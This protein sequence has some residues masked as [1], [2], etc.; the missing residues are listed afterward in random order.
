VS[1]MLA[2]AQMA[3]WYLVERA[4]S[5]SSPREREQALRAIYARHSADVLGVCGWWLG[6][7]DAAMDAAQSTFEVAIE[8]LAGVGPAGAPTLRDPDKLGAWLRGIAKNQCRAAWRRRDREGEFPEEDLEDAEH[9]VRASRR[10]Q[11]QVDRMLDSVAASFTQRQQAIFRLVLRQGIRGQALAAELGVSEKDANDA[12]YENQALVLDGFGAYVLARDGRAYCGGLARILDQAA[13]NGETFTRVL[14]L[15]ILRHLDDC[16]ICDNCRTCNVQ[17]RRLIKPYTPVII[18]ILIAAELRHRIYN[19]IRRI[20]TPPVTTAPGGKDADGQRPTSAVK[21]AA[22]DAMFE[23]VISM[24]P[25]PAERDR[26][27]HRPRRRRSPRTLGKRAAL[28]A[29]AAAVIIAGIVIVPRMLA[30]PRT[31]G[32]SSVSQ[33]PPLQLTSTSTQVWHLTPWSRPGLPPAGSSQWRFLGNCAL[34]SACT[35]TL[36]VV[37]YTIGPDG[38]YAPLGGVPNPNILHLH[39]VPGGYQ[40]IDTFSRICLGNTRGPLETLRNRVDIKITSSIET[41][42][43]R[44]AV[45]MAIV[46]IFSVIYS[47]PVDQAAGCKETSDTDTAQATLGT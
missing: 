31:P 28:L 35:Y 23:A 17:K 42:G 18:P 19:F 33:S 13:W 26:H 21:G 3:D 38:W 39:S 40:G 12:T 47:P 15:R 34:A 30:G 43:R 36:Q 27:T 29:A 20:C 4:V 7:P 45:K 24:P 25:K 6:D 11:A 5:P 32:S 16:K 46:W 22:V 44:Q 10:R 41:H 1:E 14:R 9:E 2:W 8:D 37:K